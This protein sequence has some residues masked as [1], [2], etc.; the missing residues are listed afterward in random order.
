MTGI[1]CTLEK[2]NLLS[3]AVYLTFQREGTCCLCGVWSRDGVAEDARGQIPPSSLLPSQPSQGPRRGVGRSSAE[4]RPEVTASGSRAT[5]LRRPRGSAAR[6]PPTWPA[7]PPRPRPRPARGSRSPSRRRRRV[8]AAG[9]E[10]CPSASHPGGTPL[11]HTLERDTFSGWLLPCLHPP[12]PSCTPTPTSK[13]PLPVPV[14]AASSARPPARGT[15][16]ARRRTGRLGAGGQCRHQPEPAAALAGDPDFGPLVAL[17]RKFLEPLPEREAPPVLGQSPFPSGVSS[18]L[19]GRPQV[20]VASGAAGRGSQGRRSLRGV[21]PG[22]E[23][24]GRRQRFRAH[25][26]LVLAAASF[27]LRGQRILRQ[28]PGRRTPRG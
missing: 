26:A 3:L 10:P 12:S 5:L 9:P 6:L 22:F 11:P 23:R 14:T 25:R 19:V 8:W 18:A 27:K 20:R 2:R 4:R 13:S 15:R 16:S 21:E 1:S 28:R 24:V 17:G 7:R